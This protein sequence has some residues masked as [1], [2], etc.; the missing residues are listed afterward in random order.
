MVITYNS[1]LPPRL[2]ARCLVL[3]APPFST[4][5]GL[6]LHDF[7]QRNG[8]TKDLSKNYT[9]KLTI[10]NLTTHYPTSRQGLEYANNIPCKRLDVSS[11]VFLGLPDPLAK[12][13]HLL[14]IICQKQKFIGLPLS[15]STWW[16]FPRP[17]WWSLLPYTLAT[18]IIPILVKALQNKYPSNS[19]Q[20]TSIGLYRA[21]QS[22]LL[23]C[24]TN[25]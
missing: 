13:T 20:P 12:V 24:S 1:H 3:A 9:K 25:F 2:S 8:V 14:L 22:W 18:P 21:H 4:S 10:C 5:Q 19:W 23:H 6:F 16:F 15:E 7:R 11:V 17:L